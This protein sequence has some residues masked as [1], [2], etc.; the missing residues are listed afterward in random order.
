MLA[1]AAR[2]GA[3]TEPVA[4]FPVTQATNNNGF[5]RFGTQRPNLTSDH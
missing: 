4:S 5:A 1:R 3:V 2:D